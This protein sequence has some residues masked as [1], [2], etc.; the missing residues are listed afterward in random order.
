MLMFKLHRI[1]TNQSKFEVRLHFVVLLFAIYKFILAI[2]SY[3]YEADK[4]STSEEIIKDLQ[5]LLLTNIEIE[6]LIE[7]D[8][9]NNLMITFY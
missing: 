8:Q 7:I 6:G 5:D 3:T 9:Y 4:I 2:S 1:K